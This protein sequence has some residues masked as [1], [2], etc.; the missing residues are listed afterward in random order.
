[1]KLIEE[2]KRSD[3][4]VM[5]VGFAIIGSLLFFF[6]KRPMVGQVF[7]IISASLIPIFLLSAFLSRIILT[8]W[9]KLAVVLGWIN[10]RILLSVV[11]FVLL[12]PFALISRLFT[13][14]PLKLSLKSKET[15]VKRGHV[16]EK[17]DLE[18]PW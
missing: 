1:M 10:G 6:S 14:D 11:F 5:V 17:R 8:L 3:K 12:I 13:K 7:L 16:F 2:A 9:F 18:N 15:F 4:I